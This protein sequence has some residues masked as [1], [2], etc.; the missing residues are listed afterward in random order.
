M[1]P[2]AAAA[3]TGP[4]IFS[5][6]NSCASGGIISGAVNDSVIASASVSRVIAK[7]NRDAVTAISTPRRRCERIIS[8]VKRGRPFATQTT[9]AIALPVA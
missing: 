4:R 2:S 7:K 3:N 1:K 9:A 6:R 8:R 5:P